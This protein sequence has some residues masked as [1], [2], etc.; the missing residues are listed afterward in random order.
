MLRRKV[1]NILIGEDKA[2]EN[3]E[4]LLPDNQIL[5][6]FSFIIGL[7]TTIIHAALHALLKIGAY[8]CRTARLIAD[9]EL[10]R[11]YRTIVVLDR[12]KAGTT[13]PI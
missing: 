13:L 11:F 10:V 6:I 1:E 9:N 5:C 7:R 4:L 12:V 8:E 3:V 2:P